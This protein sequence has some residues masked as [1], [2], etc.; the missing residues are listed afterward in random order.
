MRG[1]KNKT[2]GNPLYR[3]K[4]KD[5]PHEEIKFRMEVTKRFKAPL[6]RLANEGVRISSRSTG[7]LLNSKSEFYQPTI[8]RLRV[9]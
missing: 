7:Q 2:E 6:T 1:L 5:H 3:H 8:V 4:I 9:D